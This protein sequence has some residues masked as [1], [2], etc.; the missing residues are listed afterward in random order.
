MRSGP[1][2]AGVLA[3]C[4]VEMKFR[5]LTLLRFVSNQVL[6]AL[7]L[8]QF[9]EMCLDVLQEVVG[10]LLFVGMKRGNKFA[11][12]KEFSIRSLVAFLVA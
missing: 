10:F 1:P 9:F 11:D 8:S 12:L 6:L 7:Q 3:Q 5:N 4:V 2:K